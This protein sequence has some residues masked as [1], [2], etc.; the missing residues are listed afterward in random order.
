MQTLTNVVISLFDLIESETAF[1]KKNIIDIV[2]MIL[3]LMGAAIAAFTGLTM[4]LMAL[5][6]YLQLHWAAPWPF[7][8]VA[9]LCFSIAGIFLWIA[10]RMKN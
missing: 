2:I 9:L 4:I 7:I 6:E 5:F 8:L 10:F 1:L 3:F